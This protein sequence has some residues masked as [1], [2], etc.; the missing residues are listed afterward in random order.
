MLLPSKTDNG[1]E[2]VCGAKAEL[3]LGHAELEVL[4][5]VGWRWPNVQM[6]GC[7]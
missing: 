7:V 2:Q 5:H 1:E 3:S 6:I 4:R